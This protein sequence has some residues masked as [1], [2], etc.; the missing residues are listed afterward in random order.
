M[1]ILLSRENVYFRFRYWS[2]FKNWKKNR[3]LRRKKQ[4]RWRFCFCLMYD[5]LVKPKKANRKSRK[6]VIKVHY[7]FS[8]PSIYTHNSS[9]KTNISNKFKQRSIYN[10]YQNDW[11]SSEPSESSAISSF[12]P[13]PLPYPS[14]PLLLLLNFQ[15]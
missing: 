14:P 15:E 2:N 13:L 12:L 5:P 3:T 7:M 8:T 11:D 9:L 1:A 4:K 6:V 10:T